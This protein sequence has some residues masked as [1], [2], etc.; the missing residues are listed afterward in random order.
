MPERCS[1]GFADLLHA[2]RQRRAWDV[3]RFVATRHAR[4]VDQEKEAPGGASSVC[5]FSLDHLR[6]C[7]T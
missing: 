3:A 4:A 5:R 6:G 2:A 1:C 7:G